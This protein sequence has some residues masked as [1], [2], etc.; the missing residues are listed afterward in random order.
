MLRLDLLL[1]PCSQV[2]ETMFFDQRNFLHPR[3]MGLFLMI[4]VIF[5]TGLL[6]QCTVRSSYKLRDISQKKI[7]ITL[8]TNMDRSAHN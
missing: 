1:T 7:S 8:T 5:L 6:Y 2:P 4:S 3:P